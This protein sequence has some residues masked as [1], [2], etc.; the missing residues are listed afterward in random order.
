[1]GDTTRGLYDKFTIRRT[2]GADLIV[3]GKHWECEYFVLD[4]THDKFARAALLAYADACAA[5]YPLLAA[6]LRR[7]LTVGEAIGDKPGKL[8]PLDPSGDQR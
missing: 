6:D 2:D 4:R 3:G 7:D 5:E 8:Y 1:M